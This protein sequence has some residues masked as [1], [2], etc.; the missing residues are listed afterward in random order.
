MKFN[1]QTEKKKFDEAW[2]ETESTCR[3]YGMQEEKIQE[4]KAYDWDEFK[5][6]RVFRA[7]N[8]YFPKSPGAMEDELEQEAQNPIY[9]KFIDA[10]SVLMLETDPD[11]HEGWVYE[12]E[13]ERIWKAVR[14]LNELDRE[15][16]TLLVFENFTQKEIAEK[17]GVS[18]AAV[19]LRYKNIR[20]IFGKYYSVTV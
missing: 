17:W 3:K 12:I 14:K 2:E 7:H 10:C 15:L 5:R 1:Y 9:K 20:K 16:I 18:P 19:S 8:Q 4:L 11:D 13:D 6:E